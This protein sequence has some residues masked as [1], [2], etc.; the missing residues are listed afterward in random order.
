MGAVEGCVSIGDV[1]RGQKLACL[2]P[3][4]AEPLK[5]ALIRWPASIAC[6]FEG[7]RDLFGGGTREGAAQRFDEFARRHR[8]RARRATALGFREH[9]E[10]E[11]GS[12]II[13][14]CTAAR[15]PVEHSAEEVAHVF[16]EA[17]GRSHGGG[18]LGCRFRAAS[19]PGD[20]RNHRC[21]RHDEDDDADRPESVEA[22]HLACRL[23]AVLLG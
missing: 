20:K 2:L 14:G 10:V 5:R 16:A 19:Q 13:G 12:R 9:F 18:G 22:N 8:G 17:P 7:S 21:D 11:T 4:V 15:G 1:G 23:I 3:A 6:L